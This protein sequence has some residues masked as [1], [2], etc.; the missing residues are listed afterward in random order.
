[1]L[2]DFDERTKAQMTLMATEMEQSATPMSDE[3]DE[4][5]MV[6]ICA[7]ERLAF[8]ALLDRHLKAVAGFAY[9]MLIDTA[10]AEDVAQ[11]TFLRLWRDRQKWR[12]EAKLQTWLFRVARNL[13]IDRFR[14]KEVVTDKVPEQIDPRDGPSADLQRSQSAGLVNNAVAQ[15]PERQR[16]AIALIY[17]QDLSNIEA[18]GILGI[19][20]DALESLLSRGR[21]HLKKRLEAL[22]PHLLEN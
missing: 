11:E 18:A 6:H 7:G 15:L 16:A 12:P 8:T 22:K 5:L 10:E 19:S 17:H 4:A 21:R 1:V 2:G 3:S 14:R 20:V 13:C 9:R